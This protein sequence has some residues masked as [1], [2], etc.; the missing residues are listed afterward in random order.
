[1]AAHLSR[2]QAAAASVCSS[3]TAVVE[4]VARCTL[5]QSWRLDAFDCH[6]SCE[7]GLSKAWP[8]VVTPWRKHLR[9]QPTATF[10]RAMC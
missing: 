6:L 4:S 5:V 2:V 1:M 3:K 7:E 8:S 9:Q 10:T